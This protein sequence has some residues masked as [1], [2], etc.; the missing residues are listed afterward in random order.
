MAEAHLDADDL[1]RDNKAF[2]GLRPN[3]RSLKLGCTLR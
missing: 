2:S 1:R 3:G